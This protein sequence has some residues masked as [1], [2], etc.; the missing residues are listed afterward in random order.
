ME[1][2]RQED[3]SG[4]HFLLQGIFLTQQLNP[5]LL[6]LPHCRQILYCLSYQGSPTHSTHPGYSWAD[7]WA[8]MSF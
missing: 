3:W 5:R 1:L 2:S 7:F 4:L 8:L 6:L